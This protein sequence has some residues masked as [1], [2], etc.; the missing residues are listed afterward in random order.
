MLMVSTKTCNNPEIFSK[1]WLHESMRVFYDR[2]T[3]VHDQDWFTHAAVE[4]LNRHMKQ[5]WTHT[6]LFEVA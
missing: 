5:P 2:L 3:T 6:D 1:L 4:L